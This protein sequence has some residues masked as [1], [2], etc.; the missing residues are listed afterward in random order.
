MA[1]VFPLKKP[2]LRHGELQ[3]SLCIPHHLHPPLT[4]TESNQ[5]QTQRQVRDFVKSQRPLNCP[6]YQMVLLGHFH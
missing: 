4:I 2:G 3:K 1:N 5:I 6:V